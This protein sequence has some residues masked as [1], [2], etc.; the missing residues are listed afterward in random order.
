M[1]GG[2]VLTSGIAGDGCALAATEASAA[3]SV[4]FVS[5]AAGFNFRFFFFFLPA[6][7]PQLAVSP[8]V[9][10]FFTW[11]K[12]LDK[13][14]HAASNCI[15]WCCCTSSTQWVWPYSIARSEASRP[16]ASG[17]R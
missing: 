10:P 9:A 7:A 3:A 14:G 12:A 4:F 11:R 8:C 6:L 1:G 5:L 2:A 15:D 16:S 13:P 17:C